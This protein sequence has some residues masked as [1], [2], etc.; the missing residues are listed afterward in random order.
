[1][2]FGCAWY[3]DP[4][5]AGEIAELRRANFMV[6]PGANSIRP[7]ITA[8]RARLESGRLRV[9]AGKCPNLVNEAGLY[10]WTEGENGKAETPVDAHNHALAALRYLI[11]SLDRHG[12]KTR[13]KIATEGD[14]KTPEQR[15]VEERERRYR[16]MMESD[17][18]DVWWGLG[19]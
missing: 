14:G 16:E 5:G 15:A 11:A 8:V 9:I 13:P 17:D 6:R 7:G 3:A 12:L 19:W 2:P 10:R 4:A 18:R 1:L